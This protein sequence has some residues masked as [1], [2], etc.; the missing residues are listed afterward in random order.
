MQFSGRPKKGHSA[1]SQKTIKTLTR[2]DIRTGLCVFS[3]HCIQTRQHR[4][5]NED[6]QRPEWSLRGRPKDE[7]VDYTWCMSN[8]PQGKR[9]EPDIERRSISM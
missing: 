3:K 8:K 7:V 2:D 9:N 4:S 1:S 6:K 5:Q